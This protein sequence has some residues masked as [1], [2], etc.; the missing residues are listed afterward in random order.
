MLANKLFI[1]VSPSPKPVEVQV[2]NP[3]DIPPSASNW[4]IAAAV[5]VAAMPHLWQWLGGHQKARNTLTE[6]LLQKLTDSYQLASITNDTFRQ[7]IEKIAEKPTEIA[8]NNSRALQN[9]SDEIVDLRGQVIVLNKR[10]E[11]LAT[12]ITREAQNR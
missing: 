5:I 8:E 2:T 9:L 11:Q 12:I 1:A 10:I 7:M 4:G 3:G 6:T